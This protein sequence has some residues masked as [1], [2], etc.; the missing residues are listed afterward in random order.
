MGGSVSA[1]EGGPGWAGGC[2]SQSDSVRRYRER[3]PERVQE[4]QR[5]Y[6]EKNKEKILQKARERRNAD[7]LAREKE[8]AREAARR[9]VIRAQKAAKYERERDDMLA[10]NRVWRER[11]RDQIS[12]YNRKHYA[13]NKLRYAARAAVN[14]A[15]RSG[16]LSKPETCQRC[17]DRGNLHGHHHSYARECWLDVEWLC[18][19]CHLR[20]HAQE[21]AA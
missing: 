14:S 1:R 11:S 4:A 17:G 21:A 6:R 12:E 7:P 3:H 16:T 15:V 19:K 9:D 13:S 5:R 18:K 8:R 2:V 10:R 20:H